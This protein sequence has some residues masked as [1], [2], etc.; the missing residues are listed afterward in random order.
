MSIFDPEDQKSSGGGIPDEITEDGVYK[1]K[2]IDAFDSYKVN[3]EDRDDPS[4]NRR[5]QLEL[6][7]LKAVRNE[8]GEYEEL[9]E[10]FQRRKEQEGNTARVA[11]WL[12]RDGNAS[13]LEG[14]LNILN[15]VAG[16]PPDDQPSKD[17]REKYA[18]D[19]PNADGDYEMGPLVDEMEVNCSALLG[20]DFYGQIQDTDDDYPGL[21]PWYAVQVGEENQTPFDHPTKGEVTPENGHLYSGEDK[22]S[23]RAKQRFE[24]AAESDYSGEA[25]TN[26]EVQEEVPF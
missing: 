9:E 13:M 20:R 3:P 10:D 24:E 19:D 8:D 22:A 7:A 23:K 16:S 21:F 17:L 6:K 26:G 25:Q 18:V 5:I 11:V 4:R 1:F 14:N 2:V 12:S 15:C